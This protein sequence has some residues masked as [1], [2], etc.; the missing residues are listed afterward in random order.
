MKSEI[1]TLQDFVK[2]WQKKH[3]QK[4]HTPKKV[5]VL[6]GIYPLD[7]VLYNGITLGHFYH[8]WGK[9][10]TY[11]TTTMY[12]I[13]ASLQSICR[14]CYKRQEACKCKSK[15]PMHILYISTEN[16]V[17]EEYM[18]SLG[19]KVDSPQFEILSWGDIRDISLLVEEAIEKE[20]LD[21]IVVDSI[22]QFLTGEE[23][24][25]IEAEAIAIKAR[26]MRRLIDAWQAARFRISRPVT[27]FF[28]N[29]VRQDVQS[30][31]YAR[32]GYITPLG[33]AV[34]HASSVK[35]KFEVVKRQGVGGE[36]GKRYFELRRV[37]RLTNQKSQVAPSGR[38][39]FLE[40]QVQTA[41]LYRTSEIVN[42]TARLF[43]DAKKL[44]LIKKTASYEV[45]GEKFSTLDEL[46]MK[47]QNDNLF[48]C[49]LEEEVLK[50]VN[51]LSVEQLVNVDS[52]LL[53]EEE[54][55]E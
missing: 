1:A 37:V 12:Y 16:K 49:K 23:G 27:F 48:F 47:L 2:A 17:D 22:A 20:I 7:F 9:E 42:N 53:K 34:K 35:V 13:I 24:D 15:E 30:A 4:F 46:K 50:T 11:K 29:Q 10:N 25:D 28:I 52:S 31:G 14:N 18:K 51:R 39:D 43:S 21:V 36:R 32:S 8:F 41:G 45:L 5:N 6:T 3:R 26:Y 44:G 40:F 19:V 38:G 54:P 33:H 55:D